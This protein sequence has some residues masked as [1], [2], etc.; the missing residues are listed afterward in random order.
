MQINDLQNQSGSSLRKNGKLLVLAIIIII[1]FFLYSLKL[2]SLQVVEGDQYRKQSVTISRQV[3]T[4]PAQRGEIFDRNAN[5]PMVINTDSF[6]VDL[7]P[8]NIPKGYYDTVAM[9]LSRYLNIAKNDIDKK[10]PSNMR[11][12]FSSIEI[13]TNVSFEV[14]SNIA[15]NI[16][17]LPGV[18]WRSK[19]IRNYV[20]TGSICHV[21]GYVGDITKEEIN[22][23]YNKGYK[24]NSIVGKTGIEKQYDSLLQGVPGRESRTVDVRGRILND[25]PII[26]A[27]QMGKNLVLTID[28]KI[29]TLAEKALGERVG[30]AVVLKPSTGEVLAMV[31]Y[32]FFNANLFSTDDAAAEYTRLAGS[33]NN[34]LLNR[35]VNAV[36]PPASTFKTIMTTAVLNEKALPAEKKIECTGKII[37]GDRTF[38]CH[39]PAPGHG[40]LDLKNGL[41][42]S[43]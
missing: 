31:S 23:M 20:E 42:Q 12:S 43:C 24:T 21:I 16:T 30:A 40:W 37:Y 35:A 38:K 26:E 9:K 14:I 13:K 2:F 27:P 3:K 32:P 25:A 17:D 33:E 19:P 36:Y 28:S 5:L 7:I 22:F 11:G 10:V 18:S 39:K 4:I 6:A 15:E 34:P 29:Q 41:A 1:C 8:G